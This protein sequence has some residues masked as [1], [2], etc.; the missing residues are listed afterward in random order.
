MHQRAPLP[1]RPTA[2]PA[3]VRAAAAGAG[4]DRF[5][6]EQRDGGSFAACLCATLVLEGFVA[7]VAS[8]LRVRGTALVSQAVHPVVDVTA[9]LVG[10]LVLQAPDAAGR[11]DVAVDL[12]GTD[13]YGCPN[14]TAS[15]HTDPLAG[16]SE[17]EVDLVGSY[18]YALDRT[19]H[20]VE[21]VCFTTTLVVPGSCRTA[22]RPPQGTEDGLRRDP[23]GW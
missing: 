16:G 20:L 5:L 22:S 23:G 13:A 14:L 3:A 21:D 10:S 19:W 9:D 7:D 2:G 15:L 17:D 12:T 6:V 4:R 1:G 11:A 8:C 18:R